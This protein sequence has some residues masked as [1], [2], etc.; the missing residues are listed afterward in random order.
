MYCS[1]PLHWSQACLHHRGLALSV[2]SIKD[3]IRATDSNTVR[4]FAFSHGGRV[5]FRRS[6]GSEINPMLLLH[7]ESYPFRFVVEIL[8]SL[9]GP[10]PA[11]FMII[12][13]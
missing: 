2:Y 6:D 12:A 8:L 10:Y 4:T 5:T 3:G 11:L 9:I 7:T 13:T 1:P